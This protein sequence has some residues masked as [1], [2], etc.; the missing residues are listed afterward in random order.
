MGA[1]QLQQISVLAVGLARPA[2]AALAALLKP[3]EF[4]PRFAADSAEAWRAIESLRPRLAIVGANMPGATSFLASCA[5]R[6]ELPCV[7]LCRP[8]VDRK[9]LVDLLEAGALDALGCQTL[10]AS[11]SHELAEARGT[12][13]DTLRDASRAR[14][15][16]RSPGSSTLH[17]LGSELLSTP[18]ATRHGHGHGHE[19]P[20]LIAVAAATGGV[21]ALR[22][23]LSGLPEDAP[24]LVV[25]QH[26]THAFVEAA[27]HSLAKACRLRVRVA[28]HGDRVEPGLALLAPGNR[29]MRAI[30]RGTG[31]RV[32]IIDGP[33]VARHRPSA[34]VL[35][36]SAAEA[37]GSA[38]I[39]VILSGA[40]QDGCDGARSLKRS[41]AATFAQDEMTS[42]AFGMPSAAIA[43]GAIDEIAAHVH[44]P[45][46]LLRRAA[47]PRG[48]S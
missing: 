44:L 14:I 2:D 22:V 38:A 32:S 33:L 35:L 30:R 19:L 29:H 24:G 18:R 39:G 48:R 7:V 15:A 37:A 47:S 31:Y 23:L 11:P 16:A 6:L 8:E 5:E 4:Q 20:T 10:E 12:F 28:R 42:L 21:D 45:A 9:L 41:L 17:P 1:S 40:G 43:C 27:R 34:D 25:A 3:F 13:L 46:L 26:G 36:Q